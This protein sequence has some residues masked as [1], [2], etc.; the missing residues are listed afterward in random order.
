MQSK[1][2]LAFSAVRVH[3]W[4]VVDSTR[5]PGA[6]WQSLFL[7]SVR[8]ACPAVLGESGW[9]SG[10]E[11]RHRCTQ[12]SSFDSQYSLYTP[13]VSSWDRHTLWVSELCVSLYWILQ[14]C[15]VLASEAARRNTGVIRSTSVLHCVTASKKFFTKP[16]RCFSSTLVPNSLPLST[17]L[18]LPYFW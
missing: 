14:T 3:D 18:L 2:L 10:Q 15:D 4:P 17:L 6:F 5:S 16:G 12:M 8:P 7:P 11:I 1:R 13:I 9:E